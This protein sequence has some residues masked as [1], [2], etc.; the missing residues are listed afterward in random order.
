MWFLRNVFHVG[1]GGFRGRIRYFSTVDFAPRYRASAA[2]RQSEASPRSD[3]PATS[4]ESGCARP[5]QSWAGQV[6]P[7]GSDA[8][9]AHEI[10]CAA[11][12]LRSGAGRTLGHTASRARAGTAR[13]R[14][15]DQPDEDA[16]DGSSFDRPR[17]DAAKRGVP[18]AAMQRSG[19]ARR[20]RRAGRKRQVAWQHPHH[21][22]ASAGE[23]GLRSRVGTRR[24]KVKYFG[25]FE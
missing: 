3:S 22:G 20:C 24:A 6:S 14:A 7:A 10:A 1:D 12:R 19:K 15:S 23:N 11:R 17:L 2:R 16:G 4:V 25:C 21:Y 9:N 8:A 18:G 5:Q 13:P